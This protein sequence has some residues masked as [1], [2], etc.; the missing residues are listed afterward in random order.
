MART[1]RMI[2]TTGIYHIILRGINKEKISID[3]RDKYKIIKELKRTKEK[4]KYEIYAYCLMSNHVH[5][6]IKDNQGNISKA[7]QS[8]AVAYSAYF[9]KK[10]DRVGHLFQNRFH[11]RCVENE[12]YLLNVQRY[13][14]R[15]PEKAGI[16]KTEE[17]KWSSYKEYI[18]ISDIT[19]TK[20]ILSILG[21]NTKEAKRVFESF[22]TNQYV[23]E[24]INDFSEY[25]IIN[26]LTDEEAKSVIEDYLNIKEISRIK[27]YNFKIRNDI[28]KRLRGM[29]GTSCRQISRIT[30][31][32]NK[33]IS[34]ILNEDVSQ[35]W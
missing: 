24:E 1:A 25:E 10:Y 18:D 8:F 23:I 27:D 9:N 28:I 30:G 35:M 11:S 5:L 3:E 16:S 29:K 34:Q 33:I 22:N 31:I 14:H 17:Y 6:L 7:M 21:E 19:D 2:S 20:F 26:K 4:Y 13:I 15:N 32:D 12:S